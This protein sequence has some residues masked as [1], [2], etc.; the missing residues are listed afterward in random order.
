MVV[1]INMLRARPIAFALRSFSEFRP[2]SKNDTVERLFGHPG[3]GVVQDESKRAAQQKIS[4]L[5]DDRGKSATQRAK[6]Q[7]AEQ[8]ERVNK[9][10]E[11]DRDYL[12]KTKTG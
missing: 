9:Q 8:M 11:F 3:A 4:K 7:I 2:P 10:E 5:M 12:E 1:I 6:E